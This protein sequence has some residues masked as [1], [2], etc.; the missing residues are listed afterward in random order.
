VVG[1]SVAEGI[2]QRCYSSITRVY[3]YIT[4]YVL[5]KASPVDKRAYMA[6]WISI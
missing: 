1:G 3:I 6:Y 5:H 2:T 4:R